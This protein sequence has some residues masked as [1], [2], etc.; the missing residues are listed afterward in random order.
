MKDE[1]VSNMQGDVQSYK[2]VSGRSSRSGSSFLPTLG[3]KRFSGGK[4]GV[5]VG[6][7]ASGA[8]S[9]ASS[10]ARSGRKSALRRSPIGVAQPG[11]R[12]LFAPFAASPGP[13]GIL[14]GFRTGKST[15][16]WKRKLA[17]TRGQ[18]AMI[19]RRGL[20]PKNRS[21]EGPP[22]ARVPIAA[23]QGVRDATIDEMQRV[24][25]SIRHFTYFYDAQSQKLDAFSMDY[26]K[27]LFGTIPRQKLNQGAYGAAFKIQLT[28]YA[29]AIM[30]RLY[31]KL[32]NVVSR[33]FPP[34]GSW[35][36]VK[37]AK[38]SYDDWGAFFD[39][40]LREAIV[41]KYLSNSCQDVACFGRK[42][43]G[44][45][46]IAPFYFAGSD[47]RVGDA[48]IT[49]MG[50]GP[51]RQL[52]VY[53]KKR[54]V[55]ARLF[56]LVE[57]AVVLMWS[58]GIIHCD[59]HTG[60]VLVD[61]VNKKVRIVDW[62]QSTILPDDLRRYII[63][64]V[65]S[66][67]LANH[68]ASDLWTEQGTGAP[69]PILQY[70][71]SIV[72]QR[73]FPWYNSD[74][75]LVQLLWDSLSPRERKKVAIE[76]ARIWGCRGAGAG[77]VY[78]RGLEGQLQKMMVAAGIRGGAAGG[79]G[80][81]SK[82]R[83]LVLPPSQSARGQLAQSGQFHAPASGYMGSPG[84]RAFWEPPAR[85]PSPTASIA[86]R[87]PMTPRGSVSPQLT[88]RQS[89][90]RRASASVAQ[91]PQRASAFSPSPSSKRKLAASAAT[92]KRMMPSLGRRTPSPQMQLALR[93]SSQPRGSVTQ[94]RQLTLRQSPP[95]SAS[96]AQRASAFSPSPSSKRKLAASAAI[97]RMM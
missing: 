93:Q 3:K 62:G 72:N 89:Q 12:D 68:L 17:V 40:N 60:N 30:S 48:W 73:R 33:K 67:F 96:A 57:R 79:L 8:R 18:D 9:S 19:R 64:K 39:E 65:D 42:I 15:P 27:L 88:L 35:V 83:Q 70:A 2:Q 49:I 78:K 38:N 7:A 84:K 36:V 47:S 51:N 13:S 58:L 44:S 81:R 90:Q 1:K 34:I 50:L 26:W 94:Q 43:C 69:Y 87:P 77:M 25:P 16:F 24:R 22:T 23:R 5:G 53:V 45:N 11:F 52:D 29:Y 4:G 41:S 54:Q 76:K 37:L 61:H 86:Q 10:P 71:N 59:L 32:N 21:Q 14:P 92:I 6:A 55:N 82:Q 28:P 95:R 85:T 46:I 66:G 31:R 74:F 75:K 56:L 20:D 91:L 97:K 63:Q 80:R